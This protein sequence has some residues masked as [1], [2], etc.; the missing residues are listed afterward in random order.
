MIC[1]PVI[2]A[3]RRGRDDEAKAR[4]DA[5]WAKYGKVAPESFI[6]VLPMVGREQE[7]RDLMKQWDAETRP[8]NAV[9]RFVAYNALQEYD[10][11]IDWLLPALDEGVRQDYLPNIR[12]DKLYPEIHKHPTLCGSGG[13]TRCEGGHALSSPI[14]F[15]RAHSCV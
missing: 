2:V 7:L 13:E 9:A 1:W 6:P 11:A 14:Q 12:V 15:Q 4:F 10:A 3:H 5:V 8:T